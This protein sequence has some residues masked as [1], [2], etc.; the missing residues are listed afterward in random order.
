M[1]RQHWRSL[2]SGNLRDKYQF[3]ATVGYVKEVE[4][5]DLKFHLLDAVP[6]KEVS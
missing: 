4:V 6:I 1:K 5:L 2:L 3:M